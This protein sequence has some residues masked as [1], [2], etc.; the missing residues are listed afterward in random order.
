MP[1]PAFVQITDPT[2]N[3]N[4]TSSQHTVLFNG[5]VTAGD[6]GVV[7]F[8]WDTSASVTLT[9]ITDNS[10]SNTWTVL[11]TAQDN[12]DQQWSATAVCLNLA[13][14][15]VNTLVV[16]AN[17]SAAA[18]AKNAIGAEYGPTGGLDGHTGQVATNTGA[19]NNVTSGNITT[20]TSGDTIV[21]LCTQPAANNTITAGTSPLTF[22]K[23]YTG[24]V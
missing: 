4:P 1:G 7:V 18:G 17:L 19:T 8:T 20:G 9:S 11:D 23:R 22:T 5:A 24:V 10:G 6:C 3:T 21:G 13:A 2:Q 12:T 15:A 16:T 14:A